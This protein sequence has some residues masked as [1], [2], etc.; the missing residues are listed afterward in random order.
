M[1]IKKSDIEEGIKN[2][3]WWELLDW[4]EFDLEYIKRLPEEAK[5]HALNYRSSEFKE[6]GEE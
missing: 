6:N 5:K 1:K 3:K 2:A 4:N